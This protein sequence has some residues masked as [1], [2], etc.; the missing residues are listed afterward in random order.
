MKLKT[1]KLYDACAVLLCVSFILLVFNV[2]LSHAYR[3]YA[4]FDVKLSVAE[5]SAYQEGD[6]PIYFVNLGLTVEND[7]NYLLGHWEGVMTV[8]NKEGKALCKSEVEL[9]FFE[10][11]K[12]GETRNINVVIKYLEM[13]ERSTEFYLAALDELVFEFEP[14]EVGIF[15][16]SRYYL[17]PDSPV[18]LYAL[19]TMFPLSIVSIPLNGL[20]FGAVIYIVCAICTKIRK[21]FAWEQ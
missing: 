17:R 10:D 20:L 7:A 13:D 8:T 14:T 9:S 11:I 1:E 12:V 2:C 15:D 6:D 21:R 5:K 16:D 4:S 3:R 19:N 18:Y